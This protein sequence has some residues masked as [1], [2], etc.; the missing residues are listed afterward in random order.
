M[1]GRF[2]HKLNADW[3]KINIYLTRAHETMVTVESIQTVR[4]LGSGVR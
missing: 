4:G 1:E 3:W 2:I